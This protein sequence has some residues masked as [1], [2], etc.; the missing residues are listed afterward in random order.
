M[1]PHEHWQ[2]RDTVRHL[3]G[4]DVEQQTVLTADDLGRVGGVRLGTRRSVQGGVHIPRQSLVLGTSEAL[5]EVRVGKAEEG[6]EAVGVLAKSL[7]SGIRGEEDGLIRVRW[8][9][10]DTAHNGPGETG[11]QGQEE[12]DEV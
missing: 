6:V 11:Q 9:G 1:D 4:E 12:E 7:Y 8:S 3:R 10:G 2:G 5:V